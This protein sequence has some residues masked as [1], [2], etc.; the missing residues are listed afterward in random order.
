[1]MYSA[2]ALY[3]NG[4][5]MQYIRGRQQMERKST[6]MEVTLEKKSMMGISV[7]TAW[8]IRTEHPIQGF[9][10]TRMCI[11]RQEW[12]LSVRK[13][14]SCVWNGN[15]QQNSSFL[16]RQYRLLQNELFFLQQLSVTVYFVYQIDIIL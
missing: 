8:Y 9:W 5:I 3:G 10:N 7:W 1:M 6:F 16:V 15:I 13:Q 12:C 14:G 4:A 11:V 2:V